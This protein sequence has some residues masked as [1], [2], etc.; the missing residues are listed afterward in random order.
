MCFVHGGSTKY[1]KQT[2]DQVKITKI[3]THKGS[4]DFGHLLASKIK[5][6]CNS[7]TRVVERNLRLFVT[8]VF[9]NLQYNCRILKLMRIRETTY[10]H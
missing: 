1:S 4:H 6:D 5:L 8:L 3:K 7:V 10:L 2:G 9:T